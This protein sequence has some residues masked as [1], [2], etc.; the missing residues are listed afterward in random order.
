MKKRTVNILEKLDSI[1]EDRE[2]Y[3][4]AA[5]KKKKK[6]RQELLCIDLSLASKTLRTFSSPFEDH[7]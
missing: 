4:T 1:N 2:E 3:W 5:L 7:R 6:E